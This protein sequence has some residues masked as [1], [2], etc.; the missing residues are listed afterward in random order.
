L[1]AAKEYRYV[2]TVPGEL[3]DGQ[4]IGPGEYVHLSD[5]D[6]ADSHLASMLEDGKL[7]AILD[8]IE[9]AATDAAKKLARKER[10][11][12]SAITPTGASGEIIVGDVERHVAEQKAEEEESQ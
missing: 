12:L 1:S 2:G 7:V 11:E 9:P 6:F 8:Q 10:V 3:L 4:P 5:D